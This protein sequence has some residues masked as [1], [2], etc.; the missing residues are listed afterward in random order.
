MKTSYYAKY[1]GQKGIAISLKKPNFFK[2]KHIPELAPDLRLLRD[3]KLG[4]ITEKEYTQRFKKIIKSRNIFPEIIKSIPEDAVLLCYEKTGKFC[5][6]H[7]IAEILKE[8][9]IQIEEL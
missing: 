8:K 3:W 7:I 4:T 2:G 6:R 9:G 1:K 5:H